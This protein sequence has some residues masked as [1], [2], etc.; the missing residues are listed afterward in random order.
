MVIVTSKMVSIK[1]YDTVR[2]Y[3]YPCNVIIPFCIFYFFPSLSLCKPSNDASRCV[4]RLSMLCFPL[5][6][7]FPSNAFN[8][9]VQNQSF[10]SSPST[11]FLLLF[12][13]SSFLTPFLILNYVAKDNA[14]QDLHP[15]S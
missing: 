5:S 12:F 11:S 3:M 2:E 15:T 10:P 7:V 6:A 8:N 14:V 9:Y 13:R 1:A 4:S